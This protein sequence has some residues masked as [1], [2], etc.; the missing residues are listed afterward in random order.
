MYKRQL[1]DWAERQNAD[2]SSPLFGRVD[3]R[4]AAACGHS[5]GGLSAMLASASD[6]RIRVL[7][8][9]DAVDWNGLGAKA[10]AKLRI[11][12]LSVC[13]EPSEWNANGSPEK[14]AAALPEPKKTV[15]IAGAKHLEAQD[16]V[17]QLGAFVLGR[18]SPQRQ[19][20]FTDEMTAWIK[21]HL[22]IIPRP[23]TR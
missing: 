17:N 3:A 10:A 14:L 9:L 20:R 16:P 15:K 8:L 13:A 6:E 2:K 11:P 21:K 22:P 19:H 1:L 18:V 7:V 4:R 12:S 5:A 23:K